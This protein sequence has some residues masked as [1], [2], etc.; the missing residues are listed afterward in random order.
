MAGIKIC[1]FLPVRWAVHHEGLPLRGRGIADLAAAVRAATVV[2][3]SGSDVPA[4]WQAMGFTLTHE[5]LQDG[6]TFVLQQNDIVLNVRRASSSRPWDVRST[7]CTSAEPTE[8]RSCFKL[9]LGLEEWTRLQLKSA[10][11]AGQNRV[12]LNDRRGC[13][14]GYVAYSY[15]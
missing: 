14:Q 15:Q 6:S 12:R 5:M 3:C 1:S 10:H 2:P 11:K 8:Q 4:F 13:E 9:Q 7:V